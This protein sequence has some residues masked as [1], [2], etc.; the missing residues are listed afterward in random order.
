MFGINKLKRDVEC[1]AEY[2]DD[3]IEQETK[4]AEHVLD[5]AKRIAA[6][7]E[8]MGITFCEGPKTK[9]HYKKRRPKVANPIGRPK[10]K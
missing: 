6:L 9:A 7:E 5:N 2:F 3:F 4:V 1:L 8:Y 10:K